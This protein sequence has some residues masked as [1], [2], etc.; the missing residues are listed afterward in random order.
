[1]FEIEKYIG[2]GTTFIVDLTRQEQNI[3]LD[4]RY[5][6][7]VF[8]EYI[9]NEKIA[10]FLMDSS[11]YELLTEWNKDTKDLNDEEYEEVLRVTRIFLALNFKK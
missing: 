9:K 5:D 6:S 7:S 4:A 11:L 3:A 10:P 1:M 8:N 2:K